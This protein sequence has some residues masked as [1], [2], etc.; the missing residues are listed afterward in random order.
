MI[1]E[2]TGV[3]LFCAPSSLKAGRR[4]HRSE[5]LNEMVTSSYP[6]PKSANQLTPVGFMGPI[7]STGFSWPSFKTSASER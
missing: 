5:P 4:I 3:A 2:L 1:L 7:G 6:D